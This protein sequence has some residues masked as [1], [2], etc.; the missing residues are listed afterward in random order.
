MCDFL[1][2]VDQKLGTFVSNSLSTAWR[3]KLAVVGW[4]FSCLLILE[5][6]D[7]DSF[8]SVWDDAFLFRALGCIR[9]QNWFYEWQLKTFV[10]PIVMF[11]GRRLISVKRG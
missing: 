1:C 5:F 3:G 11:F 6:R 8:C 10:H 9:E 7:F 2:G 4:F